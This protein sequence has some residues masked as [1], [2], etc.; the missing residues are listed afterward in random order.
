VYTSI[1]FGTQ[2][3]ASMIVLAV[4]LMLMKPVKYRSPVIMLNTFAVVIN[5]IRT[6]LECLFFTGAWS[7]FYAVFTA[8]YSEVPS[9]DYAISSA[10]PALVLILQI[11][12]ET[13]LVLQVHA[14]CVTAS[15]SHRLLIMAISMVVA[16][17]AVGFKFAWAVTN[18]Q[19]INDAK[20]Y[21]DLEWLASGA[22]IM[23][24]ASIS[25]FSAIFI[26]KLII[27]LRQRRR[28]GLRQ[29]GP[30]Q[31]IIIMGSQTMIIPG[32]SLQLFTA[33][34]TIRLANIRSSYLLRR[35]VPARLLRTFH[36]SSDCDDRFPA[37]FL[38]L[39]EH[40]RR[41]QLAGSHQQGVPQAFCWPYWYFYGYQ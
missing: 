4:T 19:A 24:T 1:N 8:D 15:R 41:W 9:Q 16:F 11:A 18:I 33:S 26:A 22:N 2:I 29:F 40:Y 35:P 31:I 6:V 13:S 27:A 38:H 23:T 30:M 21:D 14:V 36:S 17:L 3:G 25:F 32:T 28:M 39:G 7:N 5:I 10:V 20:V 37:T 12:I 34:L